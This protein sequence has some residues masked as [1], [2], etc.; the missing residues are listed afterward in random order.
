MTVVLLG[1]PGSCIPG[2]KHL[3]DGWM[4][5]WSNTKKEDLNRS[6]WWC[7]SPSLH[8]E[9]GLQGLSSAVWCQ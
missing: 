9:G 5:E 2:T 6:S 1:R 4:D 8:L 7:T 3:M